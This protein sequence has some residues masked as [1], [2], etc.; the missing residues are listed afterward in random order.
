MKILRKFEKNYEIFR[1]KLGKEKYYNKFRE[2]DKLQLCVIFKWNFIETFTKFLRKFL[3]KFIEIS[4]KL[5]GMNVAKILRK[6]L[7]NF[8]K[9]LNEIYKKFEKI[10]SK[11]IVGKI[12]DSSLIISK[13]KFNFQIIC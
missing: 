8:R 4:E 9:V 2:F 5:S 3:E 6:Y 7:E 13:F 1:K 11:I 10:L 12:L